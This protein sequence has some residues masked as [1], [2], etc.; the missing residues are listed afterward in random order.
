MVIKQHNGEE[1]V[2]V[3]PQSKSSG[4]FGEGR[5]LV[6]RDGE[7]RGRAPEGI[8]PIGVETNQATQ[9]LAGEATLQGRLTA[10][11]AAEADCYFVYR[12]VGEEP[13]RESD[14]TVLNQPGAFSATVSGI[15]PGT[16]YDFWAVAAFE[17]EVWAGSI[18][19]FTTQQ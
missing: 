13:A 1:F 17:G 19:S 9:V 16:T 10:I 5:A 7:W 18:N 4:E 2:A 8:G 12:N 3:V 15:L 6:R 14:R 11:D